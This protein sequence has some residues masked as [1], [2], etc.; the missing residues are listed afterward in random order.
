MGSVARYDLIHWKRLANHDPQQTQRCCVPFT[1]QEKIVTDLV[2]EYTGEARGQF[3]RVGHFWCGREFH[4]NIQKLSIREKWH[5]VD[6]A[7]LDGGY[8]ISII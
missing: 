2:L 6:E 4:A 5:I 3:R 7:N 8:T 1:S